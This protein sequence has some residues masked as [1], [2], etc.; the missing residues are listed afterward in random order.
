MPLL[1][2]FLLQIVIESLP[3][4]SS[5]HLYILE[6]LFFGAGKNILPENID[7]FSYVPTVLCLLFLFRRSW[8]RPML[9]LLRVRVQSDSYKRLCKIFFKVVSYIF[10]ADFITFLFYFVVS[11]LENGIFHFLGSQIDLSWPVVSFDLGI[12]TLC[13]FFITMILLLSLLI[14][15]SEGD[16]CYE[17]LNFRRA[18]ILGIA[19]GCAFL[20]GVS[21]FGTTYVV[22]RW[23]RL[24]PRRSIQIS[25]LMFFPLMLAKILKGFFMLMRSGAKEISLFYS[26]QSWFFVIMATMA[27]YF[28]LKFSVRWGMEKKMWR[29]GIYMIVPCSFLIWL[30]FRS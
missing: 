2:F 10:V 24:S 9:L 3:I 5:G 6:R 8:V 13:G 28:A 23:L 12:A 16:A 17:V 7:C 1:F 18:I 29:F 11:N 4:S 25:F 15:D 14:I 19:Q 27:A 22:G 30:L 26:L 21:R 20:P